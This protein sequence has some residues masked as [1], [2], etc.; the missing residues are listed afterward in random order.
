[1]K[2]K[3]DYAKVFLIGNKSDLQL[4]VDKCKLDKLCKTFNLDYIE[5]SAINNINVDLVFTNLIRK[6]I[7]NGD[8]EK[9]HLQRIKLEEEKRSLDCCQIS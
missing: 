1:M 4:E 2:R 8:M 9:C 5:T 3:E 7:Y 6:I